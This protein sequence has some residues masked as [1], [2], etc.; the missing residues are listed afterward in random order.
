M[1][2][3]ISPTESYI[4]I[5]GIAW[6]ER[7]DFYGPLQTDKTLSNYDVQAKCKKLVDHVQKIANGQ[8]NQ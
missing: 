5:P 7:E 4:W 8:A 6:G 1:S 2:A 3:L